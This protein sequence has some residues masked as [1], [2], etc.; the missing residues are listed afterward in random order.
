MGTSD[1]TVTAHGVSKGKTLAIANHVAD[2][3]N[4]VA[5]V[6]AKSFETSLLARSLLA[7]PALESAPVTPSETP[8]PVTKPQSSPG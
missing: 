3:L 1:L 2:S 8:A 6:L 5:V 4:V 7:L